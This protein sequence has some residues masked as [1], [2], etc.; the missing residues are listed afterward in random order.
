[1]CGLIGACGFIGGGENSVI[2]TMLQLDTLRGPHSTGLATVNKATGMMSVYKSLGTP[3]EFFD[4][5]HSAF[6]Y[7]KLPSGNKVVIGHN[8]WATTGEIN[9]DNAHPFNTGN[10]IGCH[11]GT[12]DD[13][14]LKNLE[15][16][17]DHEVDS[18][19]VLNNISEFGIVKTYPKMC[20]AWA[21]VWYDKK[22]D[23]VHFIRNSKRPLYIARSKDKE[24]LFW[25]SEGWMIKVACSRH[26][27]KIEEPYSTTTD[28]LYTISFKGKG[29]GIKTGKK[30]ESFTPP[31]PV[32]TTVNWDMNWQSRDAELEALRSKYDQEMID[33]YVSGENPNG[34]LQA[35][36][37]DKFEEVRIFIQNKKM[38]HD[39]L[40]DSTGWFF[41][42]VIC[43]TSVVGDDGEFKNVLVI[44]TDTISTEQ[45]WGTT[46]EEAECGEGEYKTLTSTK[47][48]DLVTRQV[49][50]NVVE[51]CRVWGDEERVK[52]ALWDETVAH[53]C[54]Y[55][56]SVPDSKD[57][58]LIKWLDQKSFLCVECSDDD[59]INQSCLQF[60]N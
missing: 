39:A 29:V 21:L 16:S 40:L 37:L 31:T 7:G 14:H 45:K 48:K 9:E 47:R 10:L 59:H 32:Y 13:R 57:S 43:V 49:D 36:T 18:V 23:C 6:K 54:V 12:M 33:F 1:M 19:V 55:C 30:L 27:I 15:G 11:N 60:I 46:I 4:K 26:G 28:T 3:W 20:G 22:K 38:Y 50:S 44:K 58:E 51:M 41:G 42:K 5:Y 8:R 2:K 35:Y 25:A 53:G 34:S 52:P 56:G 24:T 17:E